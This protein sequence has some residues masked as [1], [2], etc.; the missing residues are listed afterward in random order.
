MNEL[1]T[2]PA[3]LNLP[4]ER[5]MIWLWQGLPDLFHQ[6]AWSIRLEPGRRK[7]VFTAYCLN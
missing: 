4:S 3:I 1:K 7:L 5:E 6:A 2:E